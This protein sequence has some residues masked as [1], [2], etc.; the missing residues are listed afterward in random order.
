MLYN[1]LQP[2]ERACTGKLLWIWGAYALAM[3]W[4][5]HGLTAVGLP[6]IVIW[7]IAAVAGAAVLLATREI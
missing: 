5:W 6:S 7:G 1:E 2:R 3:L 4:L